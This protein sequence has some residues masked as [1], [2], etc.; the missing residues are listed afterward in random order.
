MAGSLARR[1]GEWVL[2]LGAALGAASWIQ[3]PG[4]FAGYLTVGRLVLEGRHIYADAPPGL[5]TWPPF[6]SLFCVPLAILAMPTPYLARGTWIVLNYALLL[7]VLRVLARLVFTRDLR[8]RGGRDAL[9]PTSPELLVPLV[10][11]ARYVLSNFEHLQVNVVTFALALGGL[12]LQATR[13]EV[14]GGLCLGS[15]AALKVMAVLFVPYLAYRGRWRAAL[16]TALTAGLLSISPMAVFG[17]SRFWSYLGA[18]REAVEAGWG[19]G[20]MNQ[21]IFAMLD[22]WIGHGMAPFTAAGASG[23]PASGDPRVLAALV[24]VGAVVALAVLLAFRGAVRQDS[25]PALAEWS[26]VFICSALFAPVTWKAYLVVLLLPNTL[27]FAVWRSPEV[28]ASTR[29]AA[30]LALL[31]AFVL[32]GLTASGLAGKRLAGRLG[33]TSAVTMAG[34]VLLAGSLGFRRAAVTP[35]ARARDI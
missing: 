30:G 33:M 5:N 18:W 8:L 6:F 20:K 4:D 21:S 12:Y 1:W 2:I 26:V 22:R 32:G 10:L 28:R 14:A 19:V 7:L 15:A 31:A 17:P 16:A 27:L 9:H 13:R 29:R 3:R 11:T 23:V 25:W 35:S 24:L 34:L